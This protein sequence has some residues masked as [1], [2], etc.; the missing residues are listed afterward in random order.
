[1]I[2]LRRKEGTVVLL[3]NHP[4]RVQFMIARQF[5]V[6]FA[7]TAILPC[8]IITYYTGLRV[9]LLQDL[10]HSPHS[11]ALKLVR[12]GTAVVSTLIFARVL[13]I[14][15]I[16]RANPLINQRRTVTLICM[17]G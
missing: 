10:P 13:F 4:P 6:V 14:L 5:I 15:G 16:Y 9:S 17:A 1:M 8:I 12:L 11:L 2:G 3:E 7:P